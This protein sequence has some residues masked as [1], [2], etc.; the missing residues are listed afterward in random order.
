MVSRFPTPGF[1]QICS[2]LQHP[3][4]RLHPSHRRAGQGFHPLERVP[5]GYAKKNGSP[6]RNPFFSFKKIERKKNEKVFGL[7]FYIFYLTQ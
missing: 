4:L 1:L 6:V 7:A 3:C 5:A 2:H